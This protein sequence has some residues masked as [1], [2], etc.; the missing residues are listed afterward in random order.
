MHVTAQH[1]SE[2]FK[3]HFHTTEEP[4]IVCSP[5]RI[6]LIGEH[7]D[8]NDGFALP[9]S[10][11]K[12]AYM[13]V[14]PR[15]DGVISLYAANFNETHECYV[16]AL[17]KS[18]KHWPNYILGVVEQLKPVSKNITGFNALLTSN[19][20]IGAGLSS[21]AAV[22]CSTV[23]ALDSLLNLN[24]SKAEMAHIAQMAEHTFAGVNCGVM[25]MFTSLFGKKDHVIKL[26]CRTLL[27]EYVPFTFNGHKILLLN[28]NVHHKLSESAYNERRQQC[29]KGV[30]IIKK[31]HPQVQALRDVDL[32]MLY[33]YVQPV[34][35]I[36][37]KRC[38]YVVEE[39]IRLQQA[40]IHV[41]E[42]NLSALGRLMLETHH[43]LR[44]EYEVS[45]TELDFLV[46]T[47]KDHPHVLGCRMM[48]GGFGGCT[49]NIVAEHAVDEIIERIKPAYEKATGLD[50]SY[51]VVTIENGTHHFA[52]K[53]ISK[54][55][56]VSS[57]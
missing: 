38:K 27:Y 6:N 36:I 54:D 16:D 19:I 24:L 21:S 23:F 18:D 5:G 37:Y 31:Y 4:L 41:K 1:I 57:Y 39:N 30:E 13:A 28:T 10:I 35:D 47:L 46:D 56:K 9:A 53:K 44:H 2:Q 40:C 55:V 8:Y 48:G 43:G 20:P 12:A 51:Y 49:I 26:D 29:E 52:N 17:F 22:E 14:S 7:T 33:K 42:G 32:D 3:S 11:D 50:L 25:D 15:E 34:S 45:C